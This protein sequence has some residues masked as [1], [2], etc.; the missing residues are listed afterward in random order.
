M[1]PEEIHLVYI[2]VD[3]LQYRS[4]VIRED[5]SPGLG[6]AFERRTVLSNPPAARDMMLGVLLLLKHAQRK[7]KRGDVRYV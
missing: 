4:G 1:F 6:V 2:S 7:R 5:R 3:N